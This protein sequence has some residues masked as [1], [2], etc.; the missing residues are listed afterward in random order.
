[1]KKLLLLLVSTAIC[2]TIA[3]Q[4]L[5][6]KKDATEIQAKVTKIGDREI[7]Y[8]KWDNPDS[9]VYV[10]PADDVFFIKYH[11]G[12]KEIISELPHRPKA[13]FTGKY[14]RYQGEFA[15]AY[16]V[17]VGE[18]S[19]YLNTNR[20]QLETLH[21]ARINPYLFAGAGIGFSYFYGLFNN[22]NI[23]D[24]YDD[25]FDYDEIL[26]T[27]DTGGVM[28]IFANLKGYYPCTKKVSLYLSLD[29]GVAV[30]VSGWA[31]GSQFYAN[32]GPGVTFGKPEGTQGD[33]SIRFQHMGVGANAM[34][35][36]I[37]VNF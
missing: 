19:N 18:A 35:F 5:I 28:P 32:I 16:G 3:A 1:M 23:Y 29:L 17:G 25:D 11:N 7:E 4:D 9:P 27:D 12:S 37:G 30:G 2:G 26:D 24:D 36:R 10:I 15:F 34:L 22:G 20:I 31:E 6:I 8:K 33:F 21:G 13:T 14:P